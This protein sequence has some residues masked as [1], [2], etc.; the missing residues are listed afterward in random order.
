MY[1]YLLVFRN[2]TYVRHTRSIDETA[3]ENQIVPDPELLTDAQRQA[4]Y[5]FPSTNSTF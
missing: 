1:L 2:D 4:I 3:S 5:P